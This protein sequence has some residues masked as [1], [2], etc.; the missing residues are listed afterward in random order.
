M[1]EPVM[2]IAEGAPP[3]R[4]ARAAAPLPPGRVLHEDCF[5]QR[6]ALQADCD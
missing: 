6:C 1:Y 2:V 3:R 4:T 5:R